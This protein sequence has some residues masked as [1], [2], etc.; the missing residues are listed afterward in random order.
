MKFRDYFERVSII[1]LAERT[2]RRAEILVEL[3]N[4]G[5]EPDGGRIEFFPAIRVAD[6]AG[7]PNP[8]YHGCF[9]SHLGVLK[10]AQARGA[11]NVLVFEDDAMIS[12]RFKADEES[13]VAY[14]QSV[15]WGIVY[16]G[17]GLEGFADRP[18]VLKPHRPGAPLAHF[19]AVNAKYMGR[20]IDLMEK[21]LQRPEGHPDG[22]P[23]SPDGALN[24][25]IMKNLDVPCHITTPNLATQRSS[26]SDLLPKWFDN[27]PILR[28]AAASLRKMK[29]RLKRG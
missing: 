1:N 20:L 17:H 25:F 28:Q 10:Q 11:A 22:G 23:M 15:D 2:D 4:A 3:R 6:A 13:L 5:L 29:R 14:L 18:T 7:F 21:M 26:R 12:A 16:F 27:V 8:G 24:F 9:L 19:Y